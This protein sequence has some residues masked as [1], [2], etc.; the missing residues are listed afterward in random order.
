MDNDTLGRMVYLVLLLA[1]VGGWVLVEYRTRLG[2]FLRVTMAWVLIFVGVM[3]GFGLWSDLRSTLLPRQMVTETGEIEIPRAA[4]GHYYV[5]LNVNGTPVQ[6]MADT[7]AT[8]MV[9]N[10][11]DADR[12]GIDRDSLVFAGEAMTANGTVRTARIKLPLVE[13]GPFAEQ[14]FPAWVNEGDMEGSLLGMEYL[15]LYRVEI[16]DD[17]MVLRR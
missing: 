15:G 11:A 5:T 8:N 9:L 6:F 17:R 16:A 13:L 3:A 7:G 14:D 1:A 12:L 10:A 2:Q 4:D